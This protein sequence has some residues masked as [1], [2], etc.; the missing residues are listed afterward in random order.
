MWRAESLW[1][2][3]LQPAWLL[4]LPVWPGLWASTKRGQL[5]RWTLTRECAYIYI[6]RYIK[7]LINACLSVC[8]ALYSLF[9]SVFV[10]VCVH[11]FCTDIDE[12][13]FSSYMCQYQCI[14]SLGSYSCECPEGYQL[15]GNRLCQG[16]SVIFLSLFLPLIFFKSLFS[17][18][19]YLSYPPLCFHTKQSCVWKHSEWNKWVLFSLPPIL[20]FLNSLKISVITAI[21]HL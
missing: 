9:M 8:T 7:W 13:S 6:H 16:T 3:L 2:P 14:N 18:F 10:C 4:P 21:T 5:P 17:L 19:I 20:L 11:I 12:C 1:A 15:Q